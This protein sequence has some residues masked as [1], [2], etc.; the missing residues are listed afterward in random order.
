M[1]ECK[2]GYY[3]LGFAVR[4]LICPAGSKCS[5]RNVRIVLQIPS[6][7][8][9][10]TFTTLKETCMYY[11]FQSIFVWQTNAEWNCLL[12]KRPE[13]CKPGEYS[14]VGWENCT[15]CPPGEACPSLSTN[16]ANAICRQGKIKKSC[17]KI[18]SR[19]TVS[20]DLFLDE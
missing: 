1:Q 9:Y 13:T 3:S 18:T 19:K 8:Y 2:S 6:L 16:T 14:L 20:C 7:C 15:S 4:C 11:L 17:V 5:S 12:Q 10:E